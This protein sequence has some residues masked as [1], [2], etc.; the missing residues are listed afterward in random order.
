MRQA[1]D[2]WQD[3]PGSRLQD[4]TRASAWQRIPGIVPSVNRREANRLRQPHDRFTTKGRRNI[5][6]VSTALQQPRTPRQTFGASPQATPRIRWCGPT[7]KSSSHLEKRPMS[8]RPPDKLLRLRPPKA[9]WRRMSPDAVWQYGCTSKSSEP[10]L[11]QVPQH[12]A[13]LSHFGE[14]ELFPDSRSCPLF[15]TS[16]QGRR[17]R[18]LPSESTLD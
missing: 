2:Y 18:A 16:H 11:I 10:V 7:M 8:L 3:Q 12:R 14:E 1:Y 17:G 6:W 5:A 9:C 13:A 4:E 15:E